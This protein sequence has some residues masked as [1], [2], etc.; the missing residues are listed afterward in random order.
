MILGKNYFNGIENDKVYLGTN[1]IYSKESPSSIPSLLTAIQLRA[2]YSE[3]LTCT[4]AILTAL[5][6][7][8]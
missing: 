3:N 2:T 6:N 1:L 7:I 4:T 8:E 5:E